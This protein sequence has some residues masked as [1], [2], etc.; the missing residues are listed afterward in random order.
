[1]EGLEPPNEEHDQQFNIVNYFSEFPISEEDDEPDIVYNLQ[2]PYNTR[3]KGQTSHKSP[4]STSTPNTGKS[5]SQKETI[6]P[7]V[8]YNLIDD[9]KRSKANISL[10]EILKIHS[11][12]ENIP[13]SIILNK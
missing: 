9:L 3:I 2:H 5:T 4:P 10:F 13:K 7:E 6:I 11:I 1:M 8:E 12:R